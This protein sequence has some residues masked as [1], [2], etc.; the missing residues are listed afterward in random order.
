MYNRKLTNWETL[1]TEPIIGPNIQ[2]GIIYTN[3]DGSILEL[4][5]VGG[6][7]GFT[8]KVTVYN[9][10][11]YR[12]DYTDTNGEH[13]REGQLDNIQFLKMK[14]LLARVRALKNRYKPAFYVLGGIYNTLVTPTKT[15]DLGTLI[16]NKENIPVELYNIVYELNSL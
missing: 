10:R 2:P 9:N 5:S 4:H 16:D 3:K 8:R 12:V 11:L 1:K 13:Y 14:W 15:I 7:T 6:F